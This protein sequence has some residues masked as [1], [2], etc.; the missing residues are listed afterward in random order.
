MQAWRSSGVVA[1]RSEVERQLCAARD[2]RVEAMRVR[3]ERAYRWGYTVRKS[4]LTPV[5][6]L[7]PLRVPRIRADGREIRLIARQVRRVDALND[8]IATATVNGISQRRV[9]AWLKSANGAQLSAATIGQVGSA[10]APLW[11]IA[12]GE[13]VERQRYRS[14]ASGEFVAVAIDGIWGRYRNRGE[15]VLL[16]AIGVRGDGSFDV[17][18]WEPGAAESSELVERLLTR[19][20]SRGLT[21]LELL[22]GDGA[23]AFPA[24]LAVVYPYAPFQLCLWHGERTLIGH[25]PFDHRRRFNRDFWAVYDGLDLAEVLAR[26]RNFEAAW[27]P[28]VAETVI[29]F[30]ERFSQ[31][32]PFLKLP[33]R[34]G[35]R[36]RTVNL[37]ESFFK[38]F[39]RFFSRFPGFNDEEHLARCLGLYLLAVRPERW[40]PHALRLT[41]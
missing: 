8:L 7:G 34:C 30:T 18:D 33:H 15:A 28:V 16:V 22:V 2:C 9:G 41:G 12:L 27:R 37:A 20:Q 21:S 3:G 31:T 29:R 6:G 5:G 39:R 10:C 23:G 13:A 35:H 14:L 19:L 17:L 4:L 38:N 32:I 11:M 25:V 40:R 36:V 24:A 1:M 26:A